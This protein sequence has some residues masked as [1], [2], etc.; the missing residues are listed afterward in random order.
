VACTT[1]QKLIVSQATANIRRALIL[2]RSRLELG[3]KDTF[4]DNLSDIILKDITEIID[5]WLSH[6]QLTYQD[7]DHLQR[8]TLS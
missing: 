8:I 2:E 6:H 3:H 1:A 7:T 5:H 4:E